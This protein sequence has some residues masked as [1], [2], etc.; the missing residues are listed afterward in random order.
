PQPITEPSPSLLA[1]Y[2]TPYQNLSNKL[3]VGV[4]GRAETKIPGPDDRGGR[5]GYS[6]N[7]DCVNGRVNGIPY[8]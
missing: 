2:G 6:L 3:R 5:W 1:D 4:C 8:C 7:R